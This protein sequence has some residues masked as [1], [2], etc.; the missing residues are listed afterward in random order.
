MFKGNLYGK[1]ER[2]EKIYSRIVRIV[3]IIIIGCLLYTSSGIGIA[4]VAAQHF[5]VPVV[6]AKKSQ[7]V[8]IDGEVSVSYTH[9]HEVTIC[10]FMKWN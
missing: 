8:N 10:D 4:C 3:S 5:H 7:S 6:F 1:A 9:L 2:M